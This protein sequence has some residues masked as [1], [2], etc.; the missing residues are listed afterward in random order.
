MQLLRTFIHKS[1][2][3]NNSSIQIYDTDE[4]ELSLSDVTSE[5]IVSIIEIIG[6]KFSSQK[7]SP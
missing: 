3:I 4:N 7:F 6:L 5:K 1:K 2:R